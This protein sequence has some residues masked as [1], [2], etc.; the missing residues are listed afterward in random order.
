[1]EDGKIMELFYRRD[2]AAITE[3]DIKYGRSCRATAQNILSN[4]EDAEECVND[5]YLAA[6]NSIPPEY[7]VYY[8]AWLISVVRRISLSR[9][10]AK[11]ADRRGGG[12]YALCYEELSEC[13]SSGADPQGRAEAKELAAA[14][15]RSLAGL[16][17]ADRCIFVSRYWLMEPI[18]DIA[19]AMDCSVSRVKSSLYR[20][21][22]KLR[23]QLSGEGLI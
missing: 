16:S 23:K 11:Y 15:N 2:D 7:P 9:L 5:T 20:S 13:I 8:C 10:R 17:R 4:P 1:M 6:W 19:S 22:Q 21:R 12:E 3:T 14:I 18:A